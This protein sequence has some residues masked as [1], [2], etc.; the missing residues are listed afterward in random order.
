MMEMGQKCYFQTEEFKDSM[1]RTMVK[2]GC[3]PINDFGDNRS[4]LIYQENMVHSNKASVSMNLT[5][6][7]TR[8]A[9][10][11]IRGTI[12]M[13]AETDDLTARV[14]QTLQF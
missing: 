9:P 1:S 2:T 13:D 7:G 4:F 5:P 6:L 8:P 10:V 11:P 14:L 12:Q 3:C